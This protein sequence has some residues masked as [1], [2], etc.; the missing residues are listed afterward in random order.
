VART[1][2][3][4]LLH[5][6]RESEDVSWAEILISAADD[7]LESHGFDGDAR[8]ALR[9][10]DQ[11][12]ALAARALRVQHIVAE[13][14]AQRAHWEENDRPSLEYLTVDSTPP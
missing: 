13:F 7:A 4:R 3:A 14:M 8:R 5:P 11:E 10:G 9:A 6:P 2:A 12:T 1:V